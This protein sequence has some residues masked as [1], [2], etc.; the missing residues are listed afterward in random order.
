LSAIGAFACEPIFSYSEGFAA[1]AKFFV[2]SL[3]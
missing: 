2:D 1:P 3:C